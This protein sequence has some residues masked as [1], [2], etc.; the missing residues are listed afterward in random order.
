MNNFF[1]DILFFLSSFSVKEFI[2][3]LL[4]PLIYA[5]YKTIINYR[6][7]HL[8]DDQI[9]KNQNYKDILIQLSFSLKYLNS[10]IGIVLRTHNGEYWLNGSSMYKLSLYDLLSINQTKTDIYKFMNNVPITL[11]SDLINKDLDIVSVNDIKSFY[12]YPILLAENFKYLLCLPI[13]KHNKL[14]GLVLILLKDEP[15]WDKREFLN[16]KL[17]AQKIGNFF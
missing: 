6:T 4:S 11:F 9:F 12:L 14:Q 17:L 2:A 5:I 1:I 13:S 10:T 15:A 16:L 3:F 7:K 8:I